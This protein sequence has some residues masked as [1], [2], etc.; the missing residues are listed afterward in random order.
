MTNPVPKNSFFATPQ[1]YEDLAGM[2]NSIGTPEE[3]RLAWL[4]ASLALNMAHKLLEEFI[5]E[6]AE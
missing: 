1:N 5:K 6:K 4:G 3:Q 2:I